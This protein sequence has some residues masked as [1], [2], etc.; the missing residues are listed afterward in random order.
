M[1]QG[2]EYEAQRVLEQHALRNVRWLAE[3]LGYRDSLDKKIEKRLVV[4][5]IVF[6]VA[7]LALL[8]TGIVTAQT[9]VDEMAQR[10]CEVQVRADET[11][12]MRARI[13]RDHPEMN[14]VQRD[15]FVEK[16]IR[17][18]AGHRCSSASVGK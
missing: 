1:N 6:T 8:V 7:A 10:R 5:M 15:Q 9:P 11:T 14:S 3:K 13:F 17:E 18:L 2:H 12:G 16:T 4:G